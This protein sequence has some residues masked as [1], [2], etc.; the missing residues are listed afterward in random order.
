MRFDFIPVA[1]EFVNSEESLQG[2]IGPYLEALSGIGGVRIQAESVNS[3][4][5]LFYFA[6][7]GGVESNIYTLHAKIALQYPNEPAY[8]IA[9]PGNNSLPASLEVLA[10]LQQES[11]Q[12]RILYLQSPDDAEGLQLIKDAALG[13]SV[14]KKLSDI[15]LGIVGVP[16]DWLI[17]SKPSPEIIQTTWGPLAIPVEIEIVKRYI[18]EVVTEDIIKPQE[19]LVAAATEIKGPSEKDIADVVKV[20]SALK[21]II[22]EQQLD[23]L[24]VRCFDLVL[25]LKTTGCFAL[26]ELIDERII[27]GCEGDIMSLIGM[28]WGSLMTNKTPWMANPAQINLK[29]NTLVLAH[30]TV[31]RSLLSNYKLRTHFESDLGV[32]IQG[33]IPNGPVTLLR[34]GGKNMDIIWVTNGTITKAGYSENLCR[35]QVE[36]SLT[37]NGNVED[38]LSHPLG[39][40]LVVLPGHH[41]D[42]L[43]SWHSLYIVK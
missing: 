1:S 43:R 12:G 7:T 38:L 39:N 22:A 20:Y 9:H 23:A 19:D 11:M 18:T 35:T 4:T 34:I 13:Y 36:V 5:P 33:T 26:A 37:D 14:Y 42:L 29:Q 21:R 6:V 3:Q 41:A 27:A 10:R 40:H 2:I 8:I 24:T 17:A 31:P 28:L 30:C 32:G 16:S 15:R 25:D